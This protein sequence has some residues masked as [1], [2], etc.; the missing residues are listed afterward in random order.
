MHAAFNNR[1]ENAE[2][3]VHHGASVDMIDERGRTALFHAVS[4]RHFKIACLL[5]ESGADPDS[6]DLKG[7]S[8][9]MLARDIGDPNWSTLFNR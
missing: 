2:L 4:S 5:R 1:V 7:I 8:P 6:K 9:R 3:L